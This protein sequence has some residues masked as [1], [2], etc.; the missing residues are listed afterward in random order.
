MS[1]TDSMPRRAF[2]LI[3]LLVVIAIIA[4]LA[5][6]L[7]PV[8]A[9]AREK[10][11]QSV[12]ASNMKQLGVAILMYAQDNDETYIWQQGG[13]MVKN[14]AGVFVPGTVKWIIPSKGTTPDDSGTDK[15]SDYLLKSYLKS[16]EMQFCPSQNYKNT[17]NPGATPQYR[18][19]NYALNTWDID[20][21]NGSSVPTGSAIMSV[22]DRPQKNPFDL[23]L[24]Y[25]VTPAGMP[26][27]AVDNS[28]GTILAWEHYEADVACPFNYA[29]P[30]APKIHWSNTHQD[31]S[32][33]LFC[34][35]HVKLYKLTQPRQEMFTF[36]QESTE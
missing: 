29:N 5:A 17:A 18:W 25:Y 26:L 28:A 4:I 13:G 19:L 32:T 11:R 35:G 3:E 31:G 7:F 27:A 15:T 8:F 24:F 20:K 14:A 22:S 1:K 30:A 12:C 33:M 21:P 6:I 23:G 10:A 9:Q 2:T 34:D 36:W 16:T